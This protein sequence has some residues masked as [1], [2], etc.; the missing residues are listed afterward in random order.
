MGRGRLFRRSGNAVVQIAKVLNWQPNIV[1]QVGVG[2]FHQEVDVFKENWP[3]CEFVGCDPYPR[4]YSNYPGKVHQVAIDAIERPSLFYLKKHH[5][6]GSSF[7]QFPDHQIRRKIEVSTVTL[8]QLFLA[9]TKDNALLWLDCEGS[10][11]W[12]LQGAEKVIERVK[13]VNV[14]MTMRLDR[15]SGR[16]L[17]KEVH[18]WLV[19]HNFLRQWIHTFRIPSGQYDAVYTHRS[20]FKAEF[21]CDPFWE[22]EYACNE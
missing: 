18:R 4:D 21:C 22:R 3:D 16:A 1:Y 6:D 14:E 13:M 10:E 9:G 8:D 2:E 11:L 17:P 5:P 15:F 7:F 19:G 20:I 12:A